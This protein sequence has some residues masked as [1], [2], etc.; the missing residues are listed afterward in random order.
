MGSL[1]TSPR[2][3]DKN[4]MDKLKVPYLYAT[5]WIVLLSIYGASKYAM[6]DTQPCLDALQDQY[7]EQ[8]ATTLVNFEETSSDHYKVDHVLLKGDDGAFH[9]K[10]GFTC[11]ITNG[12]AN[13]D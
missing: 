3:I 11:V 10:D 4:N 13:I 9:A 1:N 5:L 2:E 8:V 6:A 12:K 7:H